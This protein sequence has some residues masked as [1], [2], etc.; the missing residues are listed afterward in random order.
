MT[1]II[2]KLLD[3]ISYYEKSEDFIRLGD[4][5]RHMC[6]DA[7]GVACR[8]CMSTGKPRSITMDCIGIC[9]TCKGSGRL[10]EERIDV[11][12]LLR[13]LHDKQTKDCAEWFM[14]QMGFDMNHVKTHIPTIVSKMKR[15][16]TVEFWPQMTIDRLCD[17]LESFNK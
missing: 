2:D 15:M 9:E 16:R 14:H 5:L 10:D 12:N 8:D 17:L 1:N 3:T 6:Y 13:Q 7:A 4:K 11:H